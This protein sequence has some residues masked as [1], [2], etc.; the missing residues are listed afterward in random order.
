[1]TSRLQ[2]I[3]WLPALLALPIFGAVGILVGIDPK[4]GL[5]A[6]L[7]LIFIVIALSDLTAGLVVLIVVVFAETTPLAG[8][9]LSATK[10]TGLLLALAWLA[11]IATRQPG[12]ESLIFSAH[13]GFTYVLVLFVSWTAVSMVWAINSALAFEQAAGFFLLVV[14]YVIVFTAIRT[15]RQAMIVIGGFVVGTSTSAAYGLINRPQ[16]DGVDSGRLVSTVQDPNFLALVLVAGISLATAG[17]IAARGKP[18]LRMIA[19]LAGVICFA[20]FVLTGSRGGIVGL[21]IAI[22]VAIAF[23]GRWRA[24]MALT[25]VALT[26]AGVGFYAVYAPPEVTER[27]TSATQGEV[28]QRDARTT[29]WTVGWRMA[30]DNPIGGV[31]IGN[32]EENSVKYVLEPGTNFRTDRIIDR[33]GVA[34]NSFLGPLA[35]LG[36]VGL[37]L[38]LSIFGFSIACAA[39][40]AWRFERTGDTSMEILARGLVVASAGMLASGFFI[41]AEASKIIWLLLAMGPAMLAVARSQSAG[42]GHE[43]R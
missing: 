1:M 41:S 16:L 29:I 5:F 4:F 11:R 23:S 37:A 2:P 3:D 43:S 15:R 32:F 31:G 39:R 17:F 22:L 38:L 27:L 42:P 8:P 7:G 34:H 30:K 18:E 10:L 33:P 26:I 25:A 13:P 24:K 40:A 28:S 19:G 36:I 14:L 6:A 20:A 9:A 21:G 35:E 12:R